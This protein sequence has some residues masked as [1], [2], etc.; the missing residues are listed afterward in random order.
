[1]M[2]SVPMIRNVGVGIVI[3]IIGVLVACT[4]AAPS[5]CIQAA[6][7][8]GLSDD[9]IEQLRNPGDLNAVERAALNRVLRQAGIDDV[10]ELSGDGAAASSESG[11]DSNF[12]NVRN[13]NPF[14]RE[15]AETPNADSPD[16]E[17][18]PTESINPSTREAPGNTK[19]PIQQTITTQREARISPDDEHRRRCRF[20]ALNN[21]P[22]MVYEEFSKLN[23]DDM[24]DLDRILWR[25]QLYH[26]NHFGHYDSE[27]AGGSDIPP[28]LP[29]E[30][31]IYCRDYWAEP[32]QR[33]NANLRNHGFEL[34]CRIQLE[35]EIT[36][37]YYRLTEAANYD[38][39]N[40]LVFQTPNQFIRILQWLDMGGDELLDAD[41]P[42]YRVLQEQSRYNYAY[43]RDFIPTRDSLV[44]YRREM[45][46]QLD[47][48]WLG[49]LA[50]AGMT[51]NS[52][53]LRV[54][55]YYYP[56]VF[57]GYW[58][59]LDPDRVSQL[60]EYQDLHL[61]SYEGSN[62]PLHLPKTV[63]S[64]RVRAGYPLG[65][66]TEEY[67]LLC[68]DSSDTELAGYYFVDHPA[69]DYCERIP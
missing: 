51:N 59:P 45:E 9:V 43:Y 44:E 64:A 11:D 34:Q 30:P 24:D 17:S 31:G 57:Y 37:Q 21:L 4:S 41:N 47:L 50:A 20:W 14:S 56:Q 16:S 53:D 19:P 7:D 52:S 67:Y 62:T 23:P 18:G 10:C 68:R 8:A 33:G 60:D 58:I 39:D 22:P 25:S 27:L 2:K 13:I 29:Q 46:S 54:C 12:P 36:S 66:T 3:L 6:H 5:A 42:P 32:V 38:H 69:G 65:Q 15:G 61:A 1:M 26:Y 63:S 55:H 49:I 40:E 28:L 35:E 48:Q